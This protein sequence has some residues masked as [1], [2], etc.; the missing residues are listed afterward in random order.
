MHTPSPV[1]RVLLSVACLLVLALDP[2]AAVATI[3]ADD[4]AEIAAVTIGADPA[5]LVDELETPPRDRWLPDGF[6]NPEDADPRYPDLVEDIAPDFSGMPRL[7]GT[8]TLPFDTDRDVIDGALS[9][10]ILTYVVATV[11]ITPAD[12]ESL[13]GAVEEGFDQD[14]VPGTTADIDQRTIEETEALVITIVTEDDSAEAVVQH[15]VMPVGNTLVIATVVVAD[16]G[17]VRERPVRRHAED[18]LLA[19][20]DHLGRVAGDVPERE[21][22]NVL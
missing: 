7:V 22:T 19:G 12:L 14:S 9:A 6:T 5:A 15:I 3:D 17:V 21:P 4:I 11:E 10:G 18:L 8:V 1:R 20:V 13:A 16:E 2:R